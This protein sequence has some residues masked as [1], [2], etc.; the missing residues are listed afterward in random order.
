MPEYKVKTLYWD[1]GTIPE[2]WRWYSK[3]K[4]VFTVELARIAL[5]IMTAFEQQST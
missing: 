3:K 5:D 1:K 2:I 4:G